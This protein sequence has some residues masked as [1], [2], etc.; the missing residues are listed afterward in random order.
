MIRPWK[1]D[2]DA[3]SALAKFAVSASSYY[4]HMIGYGAQQVGR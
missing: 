4:K 1:I 3:A 2:A